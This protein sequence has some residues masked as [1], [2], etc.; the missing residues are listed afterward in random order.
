[1]LFCSSRAYTYN[2][3]ITSISTGAS[4]GNRDF[5]PR[6]QITEPYKKKNPRRLIKNSS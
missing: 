5:P 1:L 3:A 6:R 4:F 2:R